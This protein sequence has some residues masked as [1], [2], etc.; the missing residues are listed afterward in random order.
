MTTYIDQEMACLLTYYGKG[1]DSVPPMVVI[2]KKDELELWRIRRRSPRARDLL[3]RKYLCLAFKQASK[4]TGPR[5]EHDEAVGAANAG[6]MEAMDRFDP[7]GGSPFASFCFTFIRRHL[8]D[9][10]VATY[11]V[12][13][14]DHVRKKYAAAVKTGNKKKLGLK[15][16]EPGTIDE[17]FSRMSPLLP[18]L[19]L[20]AMTAKNEDGPSAP[21]EAPNPAEESE[22][23]SLPG[24]VRKG[25]KEA[26][27][28]L[29]RTVIFARYYKTP[30]ESF[31]DLAARLGKTKI[32]LR[33]VHDLAIVKLRKYLEK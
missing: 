22:L 1:Q 24:E 32:S 7:K 25:M 2:S 19:D 26:L 21:Y 6:M 8:I 5:L 4:F 15:A 9:A 28:R 33:E 16:G 29:E 14:S 18:D 30:A 27:T 12:K 31:D 23:S 3:V 10:L 20:T 11:P 13:V 17:V